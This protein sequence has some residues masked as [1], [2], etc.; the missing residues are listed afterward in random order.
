MTGKVRAE[1]EVNVRR[2]RLELQAVKPRQE[3]ENRHTLLVY[4]A[5][6]RSSY[7]KERTMKDAVMTNKTRKRQEK[8]TDIMVAVV[9]VIVL[10]Y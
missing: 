6:E 4:S 7:G 5:S 1:D 9:S 3:L 2:S 8:R 10:I